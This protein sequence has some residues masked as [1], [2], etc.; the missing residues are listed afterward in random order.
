M[1]KTAEKLDNGVVV[2]IFADDGRKFKSLY[3]QQNVFTTE[4]Y[5]TSLKNAKN[6]SNVVY[7]VN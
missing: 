6:L 7:A 2:G 3:T 5:E 4:E 1:L